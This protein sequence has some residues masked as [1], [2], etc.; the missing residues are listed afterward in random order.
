MLGFRPAA[1][2]PGNS[3]HVGAAPPPDRRPEGETGSE[4]FSIQLDMEQYVVGSVGTGKTHL[5]GDREK[6]RFF[7]T[8]IERSH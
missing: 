1:G 2:P 5:F 6:T 7:C 8:G 3:R 4:R